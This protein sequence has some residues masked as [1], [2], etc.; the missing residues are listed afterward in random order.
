MFESVR[1]TNLLAMWAAHLSVALNAPSSRS[2]VAVDFTSSNCSVS[3]FS[4]RICV[5]RHVLRQL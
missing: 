1:S 2:F 3:E 5:A 4:R